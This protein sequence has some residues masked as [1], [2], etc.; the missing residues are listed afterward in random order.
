MKLIQIKIFIGSIIV[1]FFLKT[2]N[3]INLNSNPFLSSTS[4]NIIAV[5]NIQTNN[6]WKLVWNDEFNYNGLPDSTKW[7]YDVGGNGWGNN[8]LQYYT[9][10]NLENAFVQNG[11]LKITA[12]KQN[13]ENNQYTSA[14]LLTNNKNYFKYGKIEIRAKIP[15]GKGVWPAIWMLG[16]NIHK[17]TWPLC[18]EIDIMEHVGHMPDSIFGSVHT[19]DYNHILKTQNTKGIFVK[20]IYSQFHNYAI[21]WSTQKID[22]FLD[23][24]L[25]NSFVNENKGETK[26]PFNQPFFLILNVAIGGNWGGQFGVDNNICPA[27]MEVDFVRVYQKN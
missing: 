4:S 20:N 11:V 8:E 7:T 16:Q 22:F 15:K 17:A 9:Y 12:R 26:W 10:K 5:N 6:N 1:L 21:E 25:Y 24:T 14:R 19:K 2:F 18:G 3:K 13:K 27:T 23:G